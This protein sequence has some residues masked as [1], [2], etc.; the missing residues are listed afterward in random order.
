[1]HTHPLTYAKIALLVRIIKRLQAIL[2]S[3]VDA[4]CAEYAVPLASFWKLLAWHRLIGGGF[5]D[6]STGRFGYILDSGFE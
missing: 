4:L 1:M 2:R 3:R 6:F 5:E